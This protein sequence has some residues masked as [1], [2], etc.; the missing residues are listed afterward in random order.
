MYDC[1]RSVLSLASRC[2]GNEE[3]RKNSKFKDKE[4]RSCRKENPKLI[5]P[6]LITGTC[7]R[8]KSSR[9]RGETE[10]DAKLLEFLNLG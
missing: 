2:Y 9:A 8:K 4:K 7:G 10:N 1:A 3:E 6:K 5:A